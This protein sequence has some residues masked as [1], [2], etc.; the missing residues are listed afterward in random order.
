MGQSEAKREPAQRGKQPDDLYHLPPEMV[1]MLQAA[2]DAQ[3]EPVVTHIA[4]H[5]A[6]AKP[7]RKER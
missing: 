6:P 2:L 3:P 4:G 7:Q 5:Q 1:E